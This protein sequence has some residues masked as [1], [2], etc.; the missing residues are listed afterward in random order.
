MKKAADMSWK[1]QMRKRLLANFKE[2]KRNKILKQLNN[3]RLMMTILKKIFSKENI[4]AIGT[5]IFTQH[6]SF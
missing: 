3:Q 1:N 4:P 2:K 6:E 5:R